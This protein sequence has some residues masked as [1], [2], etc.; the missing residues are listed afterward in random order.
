MIL[1]HAISVIK[2]FAKNVSTTGNKKGR[3]TV[4]SANSKFKNK[5]LIN[6]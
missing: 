2:S 4:L 5:S 1:N 3:R 6:F